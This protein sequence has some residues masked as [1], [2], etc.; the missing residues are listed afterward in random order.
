MSGNLPKTS[1]QNVYL[2]DEH[3]LT[4]LSEAAVGRKGLS[5]FG[6]VNMDVPTPDFFV[7]APHVSK[8]YFTKVFTAKAGQLIDKG[9]NPE[10]SEIS[11]A[12]LRSDFDEKVQKD[13]LNAYTKISG[14]TDSWVSVRSSVSFPQRPEVSFSGLFS[15]QLNVRGFDNLKKAVKQVYASMFT[16]AAIAYAVNEGIELSDVTLGVVVQKMVQAEVSGVAFTLDPITQDES[17]MSIEAVYGLGDVISKGEITPDTYVLV[18]KDLSI[19]EKHIAP[20]EWMKVRTLGA[21]R[22][23]DVAKIQISTSW[24]HRQK[25]EDRHL[26]QVAKIALILEEKSSSAQDVEWVFSGGKVWVLQNK[27][28]GNMNKHEPTIS[29]GGFM[30]VSDSLG[31]VIKE[32][33]QSGEKERSLAR[34]AIDAARMAVKKDVQGNLNVTSEAE[35][36]NRPKVMV[37]DELV[38]SGVGASFGSGAGPV[39]ILK[40]VE[41]AQ[42]GD[43]LVLSK[44]EPAGM[45]GAVLNSSGVISEIGGLTSDLAIL[46]REANVPAVLGAIGATSLLKNGEMVRIDGNSGGVF[47]VG[48]GGEVVNSASLAAEMEEKLVQ[49]KIVEHE[50][51]KKEPEA[52]VEIKESSASQVTADTTLP[53]SATK[54]FVSGGSA[55]EIVNSDGV[56]LVDLDAIMIEDGRHPLAYVEDGKYKEYADSIAKKIDEIADVANPNEVIISIGSATVERFKE[57]TRGSGLESDLAENVGGVTRLLASKKMLDTSLRIVRRVR[58]VFHNRNVSIALHSPMSGANMRDIKKEIS[59]KGLR[60][61]ST[62]NIYAVIEN[63]AEVLFVDEILNAGIDGVIVNTPVI[64]KSL[65][66]IPLSQK[67]GYK[68]EADSVLKIVENIVKLA[69]TSDSRSIVMVEKDSS[70]LKKAVKMGV[71]GLSVTPE[72]IKEARKIVADQEAK[73]ILGVK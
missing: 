2:F 35:K 31:A 16:D 51:E 17:R 55:Q 56:A 6:L 22:S 49:E 18:K 52:E 29:V 14:F 43:I 11:S 72:F 68:M 64:A 54:V 9:R 66:G 20:Q 10:G 70:L 12:L 44:F 58:N 42:K 24:S 65:Q 1:D 38:L 5:L 28:V 21:G 50:T 69:R 37:S 47:R 53:R 25:L 30:A 39:R 32:Y 13:L 19:T 57:L 48:D 27:P 41:E 61:T 45:T 23:D 26:Q 59:G 62:F 40:S 4:S 63:P 46:C 34:K 7:V 36:E 15:T 71:Y 33:L 8:T 67:E 3:E 73:I 60:R